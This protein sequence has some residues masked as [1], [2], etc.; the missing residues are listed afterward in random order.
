MGW[1]IGPF[2]VVEDPEYFQR[3]LKQAEEDEEEDKDDMDTSKDEMDISMRRRSR[4]E[5][6][7]E[8]MSTVRQRGEGVRQ[9]YFVPLYARAHV[10]AQKANW[11]L[12]ENP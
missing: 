6:L 11:S 2:H 1:A 3:V 4:E 9:A 8:F 10:F 12:L 5:R 7:R